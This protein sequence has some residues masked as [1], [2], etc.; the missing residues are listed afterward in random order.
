MSDLRFPRSTREA[1]PC[2]RYCAI[3]HYRA[4]LVVRIWRRW[5]EPFAN[6]LFVALMF[7]LL[8]FAIAWGGRGM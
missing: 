7:G 8:G 2:E 3:E 5:R 4:P 1:F 6:V